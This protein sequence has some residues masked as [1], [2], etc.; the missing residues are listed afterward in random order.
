MTLAGSG[1]TVGDTSSV[2]LWID[3]VK[4]TTKSVDSDISA[5]FTIIDVK[6]Y[7]SSNVAIFFGEGLGNDSQTISSLTFT[8]SFVSVSPNSDGS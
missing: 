8:P 2:G 7:T 3:G 5:V 6:D 1:F 4:Q